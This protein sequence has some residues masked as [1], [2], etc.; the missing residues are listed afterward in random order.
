M[1][2]WAIVV[3]SCVRSVDNHACSTNDHNVYIR[4]V[5]LHTFLLSNTGVLYALPV[6]VAALFHILRLE[7]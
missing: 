1:C 2:M 6:A 5:C 7:H 3:P 4:R